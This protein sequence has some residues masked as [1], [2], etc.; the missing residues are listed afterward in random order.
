MKVSSTYKIVIGLIF[1]LVLVVFLNRDKFEIWLLNNLIILR[2]ILSPNCFW[3]NVSDYILYD[4]AGINLYN[5]YKK[6]Y[7]DFALTTMFNEEIYVVTN[8][9]HI[10]TI[11]D[12]SPLIFGVGKLKQQFFKS[13][14]AKNVGVSNGCPWK[15]RRHINEHALNTDLLHPYASI[16]NYNIRE[17]IIDWKDKNSFTF[18][19]FLN[20]GQYM[21]CKVVFNS[22]LIH[23]ELFDILTEANTLYAFN[24]NFKLNETVYNKYIKT[25][26]Y[27][28]ENPPEYSLVKLLT[29]I[30]NDKEEIIHQI[31]HFIFP[32]VGLYVSLLSRLLVL[33]ANHKDI[34]K[35]VKSEINSKGPEQIHELSY[36]RKCILETLRLNNSVVTTFRT[37]LQ[38]FSFDNKYH[39]KKGTQFLILNYPVLREKE[40]YYKPNQ[41][42]PS[43]WNA[44]MEQSYY[45]LM[46]NQGPQRCPA[47]ELSIYLAQSF[48][49]NFIKIKMNNSNDI[50]ANYIDTNN[51]PQ[52]INPCKI[53]INI[54]S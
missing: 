12:N 13:F 33:L 46:F 35:K 18:N 37:L 43:R 47:K 19:D 16:Y 34:L 48:M 51:V 24:D 36:L 14:M 50:K 40:F 39:F 27:Y 52:L 30:T 38:D 8:H 32:I 2:G 54:T 10:Q 53:E 3:N 29:E 22:N 1:I 41:F 9:N 28:I 15:H 11:L 7:G 31:P 21:T 25:V 45:A 44:E 42:I 17:Y 6:K 5:R 20:V 26:N 49:Y 23:P 4:S